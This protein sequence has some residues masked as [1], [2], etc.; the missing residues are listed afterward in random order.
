MIKEELNHRVYL[1]TYK[2]NEDNLYALENII[3]NTKKSDHTLFRFI[4]KDISLY[5]EEVEVLRKEEISRKFIKY[6][7]N[8]KSIASLTS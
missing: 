7:S 5:G 6:N 4:N 2:I 1:C 8:M 3:T